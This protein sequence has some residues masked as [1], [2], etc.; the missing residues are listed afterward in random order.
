MGKN[1]RKRSCVRSV[2]PTYARHGGEFAN[3]NKGHIHFHRMR[4]QA[5]NPSLAPELMDERRHSLRRA[6]R[7]PRH[8]GHGP[9]CK[10]TYCFS[11]PR[12]TT[13]G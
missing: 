4:F 8:Q 12:A 11:L 13:I 6:L 9:D 2:D 3:E 10:G 5:E 1:W 7:A